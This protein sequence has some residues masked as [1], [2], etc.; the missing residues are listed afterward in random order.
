MI[1]VEEYFAV[2]PAWRDAFDERCRSLADL[3]ARRRGCRRVETARSDQGP[4]S[5]LLWSVWDTRE[6]FRDWTRSDAFVLTASGALRRP[7]RCGDRPALAPVFAAPKR[8]RVNQ[9]NRARRSGSPPARG[10]P[11][12]MR[13]P[14]RVS[15]EVCDVQALA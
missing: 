2:L 8:V 10:R 4:A 6:A 12:A 1:V 15:P 14:S 11:L 3:M 13:D 9:V 5:H 7:A